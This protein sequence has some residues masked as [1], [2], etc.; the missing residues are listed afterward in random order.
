MSIAPIPM[1]TVATKATDKTYGRA[2]I[3]SLGLSAR[4]ILLTLAFMMFAEAFIYVPAAANFFRSWVQTRLM[5]ARMV[6]LAIPP[7]TNAEIPAD[8]KARLVAGVKSSQVLGVRGV[9][10][11]WIMADGGET[12]P[13]AARRVDIREPP[14]AIVVVAVLRTLFFPA[15]G[16]TLLVGP[17]TADVSGGDPVEI[18]LDEWPLRVAVLAF[19]R[20]FL[21]L[22]LI[23]STVAAALLYWALHVVVVRPVRRL[24]ANIAA[25]AGKPDDAAR[26]FSPSGRSDE[27]GVAEQALARMEAILANELRHQR[28]LADLGLAVSKINHELRNILTTGQLLA[29]RLGELED[30]AVRRIAPRLVATL[31]RAIEY[32]GATLSYGRASEPAPDR[33][34]V[35]LRPIVMDQLDIIALAGDHPIAVRIEVPETLMVDADA[36][37]LARILLNVIRN[38]VEALA[39]TKTPD[40][41]IA[42]TAERLGRTTEIRVV[43]N[44]PGVPDRARSRL[45]SAFQAS[46]RS[47]GTGLGLPVADE[48]VRLHGGSIQLEDK[49][50]QKGASFLIAIP[51][52]TSV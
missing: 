42:V 50:A 39:Q 26:I 25:F 37:Q 3:G 29:D 32:C 33:H 10:T 28:R 52:R 7:G 24:S 38:A 45:F 34:R 8:L 5:A 30:P 47:G 49:G 40:A 35:P 48:L 43:D 27:I 4:L 9:G 19:S 51:D 1:T 36:E 12:P 11:R 2:R 6:V 13:P 17:G 31:N 46:G 16:P 18:M 22:S 21:V 15:V 14:Q 23:V 44:G 41:T 20:I